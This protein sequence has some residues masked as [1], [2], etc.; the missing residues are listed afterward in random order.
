MPSFLFDHM[1]LRNLGRRSLVASGSSEDEARVVADHLV[2]ASLAGH[3]SH[4]IGMLPTYLAERRAGRVKANQHATVVRHDGPFLIFDG[5]MGFGQ[6]VVGEAVAHAIDEARAGGIALIAVREAYHIGRVG[7]YAEQAA[8]AGLVS[9]F[10]VNVVGGPPMV[11]PFGGRDGRMQTN[12]IAI[13][14][15]PAASGTAIILDFATSRVPIGKVRVALHEGRQLPPGHLIDADGA[16]TGDPATLF[17]APYGFVLPFGE[18]KGSGLALICEILGGA[19]GGNRANKQLA[20]T[21]RMTNG[22]FAILIDPSRL[23]DMPAF[24]GEVDAIVKHVK[25]SP[26]ARPG[27]GVVVAGE[28]ERRARATRLAGGIPVDEKSWQQIRAAAADVGVAV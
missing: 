11:V 18:H 22:V 2:D 25:A 4:G 19:L 26:P 12:P 21:E 24:H 3:D 13:G 23:A 10:F 27:V 6:V 15:P 5:G 28:P 9:L 8:N 17:R 20:P 16:E 14:V 7:A 1:E